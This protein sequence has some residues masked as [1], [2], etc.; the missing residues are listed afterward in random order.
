MFETHTTEIVPVTPFVRF[1]NIDG[2]SFCMPR[3]RII[4]IETYHSGKDM[5]GKEILD[6]SKTYVNFVSPHP[7][8]K[9][10]LHAV[11]DMPEQVFYDQVIRP[12]YEGRRNTTS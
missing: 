3:E 10:P 4:H 9:G 8:S 5:N 1:T 12:A 7:K 6:H 11:V 2:K